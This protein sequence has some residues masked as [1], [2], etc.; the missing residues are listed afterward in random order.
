MYNSGMQ[1]L[2]SEAR[3][4]ELFLHHVLPSE[5]YSNCN[6]TLQVS[7]HVKLPSQTCTMILRPT[8]SPIK[9]FTK[10][11]TNAVNVSKSQNLLLKPL[12]WRMWSR[13]D[14]IKKIN[15]TKSLFVCL[16]KKQ[17]TK[18]HCLHSAFT[19]LRNSGQ[20]IYVKL[21]GVHNVS[22]IMQVS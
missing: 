15:T 5:L 19:N 4:L 22:K 21:D 9:Q 13:H 7:P 8:V 12:Q 3:L 11:W 10:C 6:V 16:W 2:R 17:P 1:E 14:C 20:C 18:L